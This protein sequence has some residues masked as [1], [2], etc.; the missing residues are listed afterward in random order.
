MKLTLFNRPWKDI[1]AAAAFCSVCIL[2]VF[3]AIWAYTAFISSP[4]YVDPDKYPVR[5]IDVSA[6]NGDIDMNLVKKSGMDFVFIKASEGK[7][8]KDKNFRKNYE[9]ARLAG[10]K[11]GIYHFFRFDKDGVE[12]ALNLLKTIGTRKP[13]LGIVID[14]EKTG[15][16]SYIDHDVIKA[17]L[18]QMVDYLNLLGHRVMLYS[19]KDGYYDFI[20]DTFPGCPLWICCF[21]ENPISAEWTFWQYNHRGKVKGVVGDVDLNAFCGSREEWDSFLSGSLWPYDPLQKQ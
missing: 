13:D 14:I 5:G 12:Q 18:S 7:D 2:L 4:P 1:V 10:L 9:N 3:A 19:N 16:P 6:H 17:R 11:I 21:Y 8:F 20:A 15:N